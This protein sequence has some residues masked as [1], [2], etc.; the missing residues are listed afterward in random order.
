MK[1]LTVSVVMPVYNAA[2]FIDD[3]IKSVLNQTY[4]QLE[5]ILVD[6]ASKDNSLEICRRWEREDKRVRVIALSENVGAGFARNAGIKAAGGDYLAFM[7]SDD[8]IEPDIYEN[9]VNAVAGGID[10]VVWGIKEEHYNGQGKKT[11]EKLIVPEN[12]HCENLSDARKEVLS[13]ESKTLFGYQWNKLYRMSVIKENGIEFEKAVLYED[14]FFN[15][16]FARHMNSISL[17]AQAGYHYKKQNQQ[18]VTAKFVPEY[19]ELSRRRVSE[20]LELYKSWGMADSHVIASLEAIYLR[21][22]LSALMRNRCRESG[23]DI[24][25]RKKWVKAL[26]NDELYKAL[27]TSEPLPGRAV[28]Q[29]KDLIDGRHSCLILAVGTVLWL[30]K[31]RFPVIFDKVKAN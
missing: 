28:S 21:Y 27:N 15:V 29:L 26:Y 8:V 5:L 19:F 6:D 24:V 1:S 14:F 10:T 4:K 30:I 17:L 22:I 20:M 12:K 3:S 7:D 23:M 25:A 9:A 18:S 11:F 2:A 31:M 13:L 16:S